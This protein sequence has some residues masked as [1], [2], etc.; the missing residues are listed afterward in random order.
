MQYYKK[1]IDIAI[2]EQYIDLYP[3][4]EYWCGVD[5]SVGLSWEFVALE[6]I[7]KFAINVLDLTV[8]FRERLEQLRSNYLLEWHRDLIGVQK[9]C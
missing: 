9:D 3:C 8:S 4:L 2:F 7:A 1:N 6:D 5:S